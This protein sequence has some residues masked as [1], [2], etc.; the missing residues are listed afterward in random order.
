MKII[1]KCVQ[2]VWNTISIP[3]AI[4]R[5]FYRKPAG[6]SSDLFYNLG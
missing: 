5:F 1:E 4:S 3:K 2:N 6:H